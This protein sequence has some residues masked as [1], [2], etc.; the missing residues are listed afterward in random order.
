MIK[1]SIKRI[2]Q[3][4]VASLGPTRLN[5][6]SKNRLIIL[7]YHRV[8]PG[9]HADNKFEQAGMYVRPDTFR[10]HMQILKDNYEVMHLS[11][12]LHKNRKNKPL[13]KIT[14]AITFD[15]GWKDNYQYAFPVLKEFNIPATI[16]L[17]SDY[18]DSQYSFWPNRLSHLINNSRFKYFLNLNEYSWLHSLPLNFNLVNV[19]SLSPDQIDEIIGHCKAKSDAEMLAYVKAMENISESNKDI[20]NVGILSRAEVKE[21]VSSGLFH[22]GSHTRHH[23]RLL[24]HLSEMEMKDEIVNSK[25]LLEEICG[26]PVELFCY[27]NGDYTNS[28]INYVRDNYISAVTTEYG[29]NDI[30]S[31]KY[32]LRRIGL[33]EDISSDKISF[34]SR[35]SGLR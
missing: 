24:D 33:H 8:L 35:I 34:L 10:M 23:A 30:K 1:K 18:L 16:F 9:T 31:D 15:D 5:F 32:L 13:P 2:L 4:F 20:S 17:V 19:K 7:M 14:F 21:M 22:I 6:S 25:L 27:P 26:H 3:I 12:W 29:W 28:A 11:E